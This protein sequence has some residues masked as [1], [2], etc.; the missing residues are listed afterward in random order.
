LAYVRRRRRRNR[1]I[2]ILSSNFYCFTYLST[3][4]IHGEGEY[5]RWPVNLGKKSNDALLLVASLCLVGTI[6]FS[7]KG[8][9][10][11]KIMACSEPFYSVL[12][13]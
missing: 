3:T 4:A 8:H 6:S 1:S 10:Y 12:R 11:L 9:T 7:L 2:R 5:M 13:I